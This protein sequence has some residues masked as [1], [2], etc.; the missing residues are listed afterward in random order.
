MYISEEQTD[1]VVKTLKDN[2]C[3]LSDGYC[4]YYF[5]NKDGSNSRDIDDIENWVEL[6]DV[7]RDV[8][9]EIINNLN[10]VIYSGT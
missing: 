3:R 2:E 4:H 5:Y 10:N 6:D 8:A 1:S 7:I 9:K